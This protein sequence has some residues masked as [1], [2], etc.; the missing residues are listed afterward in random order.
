MNIQKQTRKRILAF[1]LTFVMILTIMPMS[2]VLA[3]PALGA[4]VVA[5]GAFPNGWP[6]GTLG[7]PWRLYS[8]GTL[9]VDSGHIIGGILPWFGH[10]NSIFRIV[11]TGPIAVGNSLNGLFSSMSNITLIEGLS[12]FDTSNV[13]DMSWMFNGTSSLTSLDLSSWDTSNVT[14]MMSMFNGASGLTSLDLSHFDTGNVTSMESMFMDANSLTSL[15]LSNWN[16][17]N[18]IDM[19][20]MFLFLGF[21]TSSSLTNLD[22]SGWDTSNVTNMSSMFS[23]ASGLTSLDL[24]HFDT[25][26]VTNMMQM[27]SRASGLTSL[28][29]SG[30]DTSSVETMARMFT[31]TPAFRQLTLSEN[32]QF[33]DCMLGNADL[34]VLTTANFTGK[35]QNV[36]TGTVANPLGTYCFDLGGVDAESWCYCAA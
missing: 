27:F 21:G 15:D 17:S 30:W 33:V 22:L 20:Q 1:L 13:T 31:W 9:I 25:S 12:Y 18:V 34:S 35:W 28:N 26:N 14:N 2:V 11:F 23:G 7:A 24:S 19:S 5:T 10:R 16:T 36:G 8:D 29:L 4:T 32:F 6:C 3:N